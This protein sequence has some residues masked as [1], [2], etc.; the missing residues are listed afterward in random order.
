MADELWQ[1]ERDFWLAGSAE[2]ARKLDEGAG[3][4]AAPTGSGVRLGNFLHRK[5]DEA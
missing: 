3:K 4:M 5:A 1:E 2:A